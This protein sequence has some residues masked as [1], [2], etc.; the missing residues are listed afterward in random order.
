MAGIFGASRLDCQRVRHRRGRGVVALE[1]DDTGRLVVRHSRGRGRRGGRGFVAAQRAVLRGGVRLRRGCFHFLR[2]GG[3]FR[4]GHWAV[5]VQHRLKIRRMVGVA[6]GRRAAAQREPD[7]IAAAL[8]GLRHDKQRPVVPGAEGDAGVGQLQAEQ[9]AAQQVQNLVGDERVVHIGRQGTGHRAAAVAHQH[10]GALAHAGGH[11]GGCVV[12]AGHLHG[13]QGAACGGL[14]HI[15]GEP[16]Q[17]LFRHGDTAGFLRVGVA[18]GAKVEHGL[19]VGQRLQKCAQQA[20]CRLVH[21]H[22]QLALVQQGIQ[23]GLGQARF[24]LGKDIVAELGPQP[25]GPFVTVLLRHGAVGGADLHADGKFA[26]AL[27]QAQAGAAIVADLPQYAGH[28]RARRPENTQN[29]QLSVDHGGTFLVLNCLFLWGCAR[30]RVSERNRRRRL[31]AR[32]L[33]VSA[34]PP[35]GG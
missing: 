13:G 30:R 8:G 3:K 2:R 28:L 27:Q 17:Q 9:A 19:A 10:K 34:A 4:R 31:L 35:A 23:R 11:I 6:G 18:L 32:R 29:F 14:H 1:L 7:R 26:V 24:A 22:Q 21:G 25:R 12:R 20:A 33:K 16:L 15:A 5:K